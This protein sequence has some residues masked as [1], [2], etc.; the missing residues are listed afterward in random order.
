MKK[1]FPFRL[2]EGGSF[3]MLIILI[4]TFPISA[5]A[6]LFQCEYINANCN[7]FMNAG[8]EYIPDQYNQELTINLNF[9]FLQASAA[10]PLNFTATDDGVD[11]LDGIPGNPGITGDVVA[12]ELVD[13]I[14]FLID[15]GNQQM[16]LPPGNTTQVLPYKFRFRVNSVQYPVATGTIN[17]GSP[18]PINPN[19]ADGVNVVLFTSNNGNVS[20]QTTQNTGVNAAY[21]ECDPSFEFLWWFATNGCGQ[22]GWSSGDNDEIY[23]RNWWYTYKY[24]RGQGC[25][26]TTPAILAD[27]LEW[28]YVLMATQIW[29]EIGHSFCLMHTV[30]EPG[31]QPCD[32]GDANCNDFCSDTPERPAIMGLT[33]FDPAAAASC[34]ED[35]P[36]CSNNLMDYHAP[37]H[38]LTPHQ[39][40]RWYHNL[41]NGKLRMLFNDF[42]VADDAHN[43]VIPGGADLIWIGDRIM[44]GSIRLASGA[45][46]TLKGH[47]YMPEHSGIIVEQGAQLIIDGGCISNRCGTLWNG[48]QLLGDAHLAQTPTSNQ[49][50]LRITNN[51]SIL[52][53][54]IAVAVKQLDAQCNYIS[55]TGGGI[56]EAEDAIFLN[57][58]ADV[59][60]APYIWLNNFNNPVANLSYFDRCTFKTDAPIATTFTNKWHVRMEDVFNVNFRGCLFKNDRTLDNIM[61]QEGT[62]ISSLNSTFGVL[63]LCNLPLGQELLPGL[64][65][66]VEYSQPCRFENLDKGITHLN[67]LPTA[68]FRISG[69]EFVGNNYGIFSRG[70]QSLSITGCD[71]DVNPAAF[72]ANEDAT[73][74]YGI[75]LDRCS[76]YEV[77]QNTFHGEGIDIERVGLDIS[78]SSGTAID[79]GIPYIEEPNRIYN[80]N[81]YN[82][83]YATIAQ[84]D[85]RI[86]ADQNEGLELLCGLYEGNLYD[87]A[88]TGSG[89]KIAGKQG[90]DVADLFLQ[91]EAYPAGNLFSN[92]VDNCDD[93]NAIHMNPSVLNS[94]FFYKEYPY[95]DGFNT[96][97]HP[98]LCATLGQAYQIGL[99][100]DNNEITIW[101]TREQECSNG[102]SLDNSDFSVL[103]MAINENINKLNYL[104]QRR[105]QVEDG[106]QTPQLISVVENSSATSLQVR[107][108]LLPQ[109]PNLSDAVLIGLIQRQPALEQW[110][111]CDLLLQ[112]SPLSI[113]AREYYDQYLPLQGFF[114][115]M[116]MQYQVGSPTELN[117]IK[118]LMKNARAKVETSRN[119]YFRGQYFGSGSNANTGYAA[120][121]TMALLH[122]RI[123]DQRLLFA[124]ALQQKNYVDAAALLNNYPTEYAH[125]RWAEVMG[126]YLN[127][128]Q[129]NMDVCALSNAHKT[130]LAS[131]ANTQDEGS[132]EA[133]ALLQLI[134][135][136][137]AI[138]EEVIPPFGSNLRSAKVQTEASTYPII[139]VFP[140]PAVSEVYLVARMPE[141]VQNAYLHIY[142]VDGKL[143]EVLDAKN[144]RGFCSINLSDYKNGDYVVQLIVNARLLATEKFTVIK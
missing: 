121:K 41:Y 4:T 92:N 61:D 94:M 53:A 112:C 115:T 106:G 13:R 142:A 1:E 74:P 100:D 108:E 14:N 130:L 82:L 28:Q 72:V 122:N 52:N 127:L 93:E 42:C 25:D 99:F 23:I 50:Y 144:C 12:N 143:M 29:H 111:L 10:T 56:I 96:Y 109:C 32:P 107:N 62:G 63:A 91:I 48:I 5:R 15:Q 17:C 58:V 139:S 113:A 39:L 30:L 89:G 104:Q 6:Q 34:N 22:G 27:I 131:I 51:G 117:A 9:F 36:L 118:A 85:N 140:N 40:G 79:F 43:I 35:P 60:F 21:P 66:P 123:R 76:G 129:N 55:G 124:I 102:L 3:W 95:T 87:I 88:V 125:D 77:E 71:F 64:P 119:D 57:N 78:S 97:V 46:L 68:T 69:A 90:N 38:A 114:H 73:I 83:A 70:T 141:Q 98:S 49:G 75:H 59:E 137:I 128:H 80:N 101:T 47:L 138:E 20:I 24:Y 132:S 18:G 126:I 54:A 2:K 136:T 44:K 16:Y 37:D 11:G 86:D 45:K 133:Q 134:D 65:C 19:N 7:S 67:I 84:D 33:G 105:D 120:I 31:G 135:P 110:H 116:L 26:A 8:S 103:G 81:F